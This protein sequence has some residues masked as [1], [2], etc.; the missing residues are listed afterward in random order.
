MR[1]HLQIISWLGLT[2]GLLGVEPG[3]AQTSI[4]IDSVR[5]YPGRTVSLPVHLA[6]ATNITAA[7]FDITYNA[8]K[9]TPSDAVL[10]A[11][12]SN[13]LVRSREIAP[14][15]R[16]VL[17]YSVANSSFTTTGRVEF[18]SLPWTVFPQERSGSGPITPSNVTLAKADATRIP[19]VT[20]DHGVIFVSPVYREPGGWVDFFLPSTADGRYLL[21][22][23]TNLVDWL[24]LSTNQAT[25]SF[26]DLVDRA[27]P[28]YP[29]R[30]YRLKAD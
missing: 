8:S 15:I 6:K 1:T 20:S 10:G 27:A 19:P 11:S 13:H 26:I 21:Q 9:V 25:G 24:T 17:V 3:F 28:N 2:A 5:G 7:Q 12:I 4:S 16:R 30:F 23:T 14:G 22:A 18:A 29:S